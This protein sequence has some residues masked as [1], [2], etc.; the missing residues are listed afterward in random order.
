MAWIRVIDET[1][2]DGSLA[3]QY[4]NLIGPWGGVDHILTIHSLHPASLAAHVQ[5]YKTLMYGKGPLSR[6]QREMIAVV[7]SAANECHY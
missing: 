4:R 5:I 7:A 6:V 3:E 2:A 1:E